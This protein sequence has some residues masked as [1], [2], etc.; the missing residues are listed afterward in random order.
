MLLQVAG[1]SASLWLNNSVCVC[2][3]VYLSIHLLM[4]ISVI[5]M[6]WLLEIRLQ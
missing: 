6:S 2:S 5:F 3:S 4:D 1:F